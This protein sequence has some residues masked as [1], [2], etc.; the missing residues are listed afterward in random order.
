[1]AFAS[2]D[3]RGARRIHYED[4]GAGPAVLL[5]PGTGAGA[6]QFGTLPRRFERA[7]LRCLTMSPAGIA[8]SSPLAGPFDF[9]EA[10][11]D[12]DAVLDAAGVEQCV[13]VGTSLG[14]KVALCA[15]AAAPARWVKLVLLAS[16]AMVTAR[17]RRV[18]RFFEVIAQRLGPEEFADAIAPFL[19]GRTFHEARAQVVTDLVRGLR[20][21]ADARA[22]MI[23]QAR[24]LQEFDGR[25]LAQDLTVP[26]LCIAGGEDTL[27]PAAEV[28]ATAALIPGARYLEIADA[29]H[30]L[31]L[32]SARAFEAVVEFVRGAA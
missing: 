20:P 16:S 31:L 25:A 10:A 4:H 29:G 13:A 11:R 9:A 1:M 12:L 26:A 19:L 5:V 27:T 30:S 3:G 23:A 15:C 2:G 8:P 17:A 6:R 24:A 32:E 18:Y 14:G 21:D 28:R 22:L 7:G